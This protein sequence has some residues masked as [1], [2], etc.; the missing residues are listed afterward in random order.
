M[1][2]S[3]RVCVCVCVSFI[4]RSF[5]GRC[6]EFYENAENKAIL[7]VF[8]HLLSFKRF[9]IFSIFLTERK[10]VNLISCFLRL[11]FTTHHD[12]KANLEERGSRAARA[13][14]DTFLKMRRKQCE[15][16]GHFTSQTVSQKGK[17]IL[18]FFFSIFLSVALIE[19]GRGFNELT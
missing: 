1:L 4:A 11:K 2:L 10:H 9:Q 7:S 17:K 18:L 6:S 8:S 3:V 14:E 15:P 12:T 13:C 19:Y 5:V 16:C